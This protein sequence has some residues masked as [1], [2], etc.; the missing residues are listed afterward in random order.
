MLFM[1]SEKYKPLKTLYD[2][3]WD[4]HIVKEEEGKPSLLYIDL[5]LIHEVTTP[6]AFEGLRLQGRKVRRPELTVGTI[7]HAIPTIDRDLP[8]NDPVAAKQVDTLRKNA[9]DFGVRLFDL[10]A[11]EQGIIH[12][13]GPEQGFTHPGMTIVCGDSHTSTHGAFG[14]LAF[15]IGTTEVEHVL[16]TQCLYQTKASNTLLNFD[17]RLGP[18]VTPKDLILAV[19]EEIGTA[20]GSGSVFEYAGPAI[21]SMSMEGRMTVCNMS[22]EAGAK[23]GLIAPDDKTFEYLKGRPNSPKGEDWERATDSW[24]ELK[25]DPGAGFEKSLDFDASLVSP[26]VTWGTSPAMSRSITDRLP[27]LPEKSNTRASYEKAYNYMG[28]EPGKKI[29]EIVIDRAFIG[30]CTNGRIEDLKAAARVVRGYRVSNGVRALVVPGSMQ[31]KRQAEKE[32]IAQDFTEA[33]FEWRDA[34][35]SMCLGMNE[36]ILAPGERCAST[37]N[38]NFEGRQGRGGRTHLVSPAMAAAAAIAGH[39]TDIRDW[40]YHG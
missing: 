21:E 24:K 33:G 31:I 37:S 34:G 16:A 18:G 9:R 5:H 20:G 26:M 8:F 1:Q 10:D 27:E 14:S 28:L 38:R 23:A 22:I 3:I 39:F 19:I 6:Q 30:S 4:K 25:T 7:D 36:D 17:G 11:L 15:G 32:G 35:C 12:V 13:F 40:K 29:D 2:K